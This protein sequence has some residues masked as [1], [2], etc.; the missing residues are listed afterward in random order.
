MDRHLSLLNVE[1]GVTSA[2]VRNKGCTTCTDFGRLGT[3]AESAKESGRLATRLRDRIVDL[4]QKAG[5]K[6]LTINEAEAI[7]LDH[8]IQSVSPR[9]AELIARGALVRVPIE[10]GRPT[11]RSPFGTP[12][13]MRRYDEQTKRRVN[14][15]WIP[16]FAPI[17]ASESVDDQNM[18]AAQ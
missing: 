11:K 18:G 1:Q 10:P 16:E 4:A 12:R 2:G 13:Y 15:H 8:K 6:G 5:A 9:F 17:A 14:V 7:I 3:S